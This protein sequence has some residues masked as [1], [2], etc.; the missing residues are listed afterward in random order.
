MAGETPELPEWW[1]WE[2]EI[3]PHLPKRM[4]DRDFNEIDL[5]SMLAGHPNWRAAK[6]VGRFVIHC[7]FEGADWEVI[8]EPDETAEVLIVVTAY[9]KGLS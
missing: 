6:T 3:T 9:S 5:R 7:R 1:E 2:L 8:V 4:S